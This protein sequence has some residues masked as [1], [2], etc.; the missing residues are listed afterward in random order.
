MTS[1]MSLPL[2]AR[3]RVIGA[4][5]LLSDRPERLFGDADLAIA[6]ELARRA[7]IAVDNALLFDEAERRG[8][9]ARVL[10]H[11]A[12][13]VFMLDADGL[14]RLW[15]R[16]AEAITL[17]PADEVVGQARGRGDPRLAADRGARAGGQRPCGARRAPRRVPLRATRP[18]ALALDHRRLVRRGNRLR[19][20][21]PDRGARARAS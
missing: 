8:D 6:E 2:I 1:L 9:A 12:D 3:G 16:A 20:P 14:V 10:E 11:I 18:R 7:A 17:L 19:V 15:N 21:R 5:T 4:L 13:G